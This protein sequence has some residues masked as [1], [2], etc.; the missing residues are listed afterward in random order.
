MLGPAQRRRLTGLNAQ[1]HT[2]TARATSPADRPTAARLLTN[3][4]Q[5]HAPGAAGTS[6]HAAA[7]AVRQRCYLA[8]RH[9]G[10]VGDAAAEGN[11][12]RKPVGP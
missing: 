4:G 9:L 1:S 2:L 6:W 10:A 12:A 7:E 5:Q 3:S 11:E 8:G